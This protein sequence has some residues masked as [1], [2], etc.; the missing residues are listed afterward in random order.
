MGLYREL[1]ITES[2]DYID[3][4][5]LLENYTQKTGNEEKQKIV[6][7]KTNG[8]LSKTIQKKETSKHDNLWIG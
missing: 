4:S 8:I 2:N 3:C 5:V 7:Q 1:S 6:E